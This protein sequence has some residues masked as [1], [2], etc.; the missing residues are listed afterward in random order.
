[1]PQIRQWLV[2]PQ[3]VGLRRVLFQIHLWTGVGAGLYIF[4]ASVSGSAVVFRNEIYANLDMQPVIV[5][6]AGEPMDREMLIAR[7]EQAYPGYR[8]RSVFEGRNPDQAV[9]IWLALGNDERQRL[10]DP[11]TG[12]DLGRSVSIPIQ[13][14]SWILDLHVNLL[15][16]EKGRFLNGLGAALL[17]ILCLT[18][19]VIW[20]PGVASWKRS[21]VAGLHSNWRR[22]NWELHSAVGFW[23]LLLLLMWSLTGIIVSIPAPYWALVDYMEP[24]PDYDN[25]PEDYVFERRLGDQAFR[26]IAR[27]HFG[28]FGGVGVK[29]LWTILGLAPAFLF[30]TGALM[31]WNRVLGPWVRK[32]R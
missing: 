6:L 12:E 18:G 19:G 4:V 2:H 29:A 15:A 13:V 10:F 7:A 20:W 28:T 16:G 27:V 23:T 14:T 32:T 31:W 8:V 24:Y 26:W 22:F 21:L 9:E 17:A 1:M 5:S 25:L 11:Y 3:G 30:V